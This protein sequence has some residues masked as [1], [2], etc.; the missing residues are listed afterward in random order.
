MPGASPSRDLADD[1][2]L[3]D[4]LRR[5]DEVAFR[6]LMEA[7][8]SALLRMATLRVGSRAVAEEVVQETWLG[9][10]RG[11]GR[12]EAQCSLRTWIFRILTNIAARTSVRESRSLPFASLGG[13]DASLDADRYAGAGHRPEEDLLAAETRKVLAAAVRALPSSQRAVIALRDIEGWGAA[14]ACEALA[15]SE[16]NQRVLLHRARTTVRAALERHGRVT[17]PA[18]P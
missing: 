5:G 6:E 3:V 4:A 17:Q 11:L 12:F 14:E 16:A 2:T 18:A 9:V 7:Y 8:D 10:I 13:D 1:A 15:L